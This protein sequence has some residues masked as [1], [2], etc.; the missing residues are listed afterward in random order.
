MRQVAPMA[1]RRMSAAG[2]GQFSARLTMRTP[3]RGRRG[4][5]VGVLETFM[6]AAIHQGIGRLQPEVER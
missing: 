5:V 3:L 2:P 6:V 1:C 4:L